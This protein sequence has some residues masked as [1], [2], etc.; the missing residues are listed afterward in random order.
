MS[1]AAQIVEHVP[2]VAER[3][4]RVDHPLR[5]CGRRK[6]GG[7]RPSV[8]EW[9]KL[10]V[11]MQRTRVEGMA[12][13]FKKQAPEQAREYPH[14]QEVTG[15]T[16]DPVLAVRGDASARHHA[17]HVGMML[18]VLPPGVQERDEA[19]LSAE[20]FRIGSDRA[21]GFGAG[22]EQDVVES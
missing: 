17:V 14:G 1:V 7:E 3:R 16:G 18:Q 6:K 9:F 21:Q 13:L 12:Q 11:E 4:L 2:G 20:M 10:A 15:A 22:A 19:D 8:G 5:L